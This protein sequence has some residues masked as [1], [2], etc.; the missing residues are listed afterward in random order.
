MFGPFHTTPAV[1]S[2][3]S[4]GGLSCLLPHPPL[5]PVSPFILSSPGNQSQFAECE[6]NQVI[7]LCC[8]MGFQFLKVEAEVP[9]EAYK[10]LCELQNTPNPSFTCQ[11]L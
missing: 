11:C 6:L 4:P 1:V 9:I 2:L 3:I 7:P 5:P 10:G 8:P